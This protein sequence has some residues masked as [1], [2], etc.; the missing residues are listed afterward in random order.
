LIASSVSYKVS[1]SSRSI[2]FGIVN[3]IDLEEA[4]TLYDTED[5]IKVIATPRCQDYDPE[6][7]SM[8]ARGC[9]VD[10]EASTSCF[11]VCRCYHLTGANNVY[12]WEYICFE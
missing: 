12:R 4:E 7:G 10:L 5:A 8:S 3:V 11:T 6:S 2:S 9:E 1:A